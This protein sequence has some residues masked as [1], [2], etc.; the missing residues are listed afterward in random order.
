[1]KI[2]N[3]VSITFILFNCNSIPFA[4]IVLKYLTVECHD[5]LSF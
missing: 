1:M 4:A 5:L 3:Y 2:F